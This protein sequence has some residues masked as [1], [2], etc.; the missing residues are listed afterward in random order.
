MFGLTLARWACRFI[1]S[2]AHLV[3]NRLDTGP[4]LAL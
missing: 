4:S 3:A 2:F 1:A